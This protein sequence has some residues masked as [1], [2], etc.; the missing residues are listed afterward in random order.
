MRDVFGPEQS[1]DVDER[2]GIAK[3]R[4]VEQ[5]LRRPDARPARSANSTVAG[6]ASS[7]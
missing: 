6:S 1:K 3:R 2:V 5:R 7:G 4:D